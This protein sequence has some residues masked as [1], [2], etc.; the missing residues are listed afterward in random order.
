MS[1]ERDDSMAFAQSVLILA[2][3][4]LAGDRSF[5]SDPKL[6]A[7]LDVASINAMA[8]SVV[9][10]SIPERI[11]EKRDWGKQSN[12]SGLKF[13]GQGFKTRLASNE[14]LVNH[15]TWKQYRIEPVDPKTKLTL[16]IEQLKTLPD[17]GFGFDL[18]ITA[19]VTA[20]ATVQQW[21]W[22]VRVLAA[23][24]D[25]DA[26]ATATLSC[27]V[28]TSVEPGTLLPTV[29]LSPTV[30]GSKVDLDEFRLRKLGEL[31][32][33]VA[34]ELSD[35]AKKIVLRFL[36]KN[37]GKIAAKANASLEKRSKAGKLA[38]TPLPFLQ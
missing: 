4:L 34:R 3:A 27:E 5:A 28:R 20:S 16:G 29:R 19:P 14:K 23:T 18:R 10:E 32:R 22:G 7:G 33:S 36:R 8:R 21:V 11:E 37:E 2:A 12:R 35:E 24:V 31:P 26:T 38:F 17:G 13:R 6:P 1:W 30:I 9:V 25:A 15:G